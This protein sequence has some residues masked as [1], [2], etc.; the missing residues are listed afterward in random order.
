MR[1]LSTLLL[2]AGMSSALAGSADHPVT[3]SDAWIREAPPGVSPLAGYL[4]LDNTGRE[5]MVLTGVSSPDFK[6]VEIH[7]TRIEGD[8]AKME[9]KDSLSLKADESVVFEPGGYHLMLFQPG[10]PMKDGDPV[11]LT[12][13][14][15]DQPPLEIEARVRS[16]RDNN[17]DSHGSSDHSHHH[18]H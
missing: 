8:V 11:A 14:F 13:S 7:R 3:I 10:R 17:D 15:K 5:T 16:A 6:R 1:A 18:H 12:F 9:Q 2:L 4:Q